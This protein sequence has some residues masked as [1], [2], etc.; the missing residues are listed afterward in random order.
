[1]KWRWLNDMVEDFRSG[2]PGCRFLTV[3]QHRRLHRREHLIRSIVYIGLG[4]LI[5]I[6][7][8]VLA[9]PPGVPG[10]FLWIPGMLMV[11]TRLRWAA[12]LMDWLEVGIHRVLGVFRRNRDKTKKT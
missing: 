5:L 11:G 4:F 6:V 2:T 9:L 10:F 3:Y 7:G 8:V 12:V 1:M